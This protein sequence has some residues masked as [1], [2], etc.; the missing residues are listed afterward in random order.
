MSA[1]ASII[2]VTYGQRDLTAQCL[3]SLERCL[4]DRLGAEFELV[5]VDNASPDATPDLLRAWSDRAVVSLLPENRNFAGGCNAGAALATG[6]VLIFLNNDTVVTPGAL[7]ALADQALEPGVSAAGCRLH[8][9]DGTIQHAGVAFLHSS[10]L[11]GV[12]M[13]Q[14][15]FHHQSPELPAALGTYELDCVTAACMSV[16]TAVFRT[17]GGFDETYVNGLEDVDLC[18]RLR[19]AGGTIVYRGDI[20]IVHHEGASRGQGSE[21]WATPARLKAMRRNDQHF[22]D[23][24][25]PHLD[26]DDELAARLWGSAVREGAPGR[27]PAA[28][29]DVVVAGQP[30]G[31]GPGSS[32]A[33]AWLA[34]LGRQGVAAA[35]VDHPQPLVVPRLH[36][37][38][39]RS[40]D[41]AMRRVPRTGAAWL[42]I[43]AGAHDRLTVDAP[44][45]VRLGQLQTASPLGHAAAVWAAS[46]ALATQLIVAGLPGERVQVVPPPVAD[47]A[48]GSGGEGLLA[49]LPAHRPPAARAVLDALR[50]LRPG[51]AIRLVPTV[52]GRGVEREVR[53]RLPQAE[54]L[55][56][57]SEE[58][59]FARLAGTADVVAVGDDGD[60]FD[61]RALIAAS[62]G[63]IVV[64]VGP[65][66]PAAAFL[67]PECRGGDD[68]I[69][70]QGH[71]GTPAGPAAR[72]ARGVAAAR[73]CAPSAVRSFTAA[74]ATVAA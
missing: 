22:I 30:G 12:A 48:V 21:L 49:I 3:R 60:P 6:E 55:P 70:A 47:V 24:W 9:P 41:A 35:T 43:P 36:Q 32:E 54:L 17:V 1:R 45:I 27:D 31:I 71:L 29:A 8:F 20:V 59:T 39:A 5:L 69:S 58:I 61:R 33:R 16:R 23:R 18:L 26:Q 38:T 57:V 62:A 2:I 4:G 37:S 13:P 25:G 14:H 64:G 66:G 28:V 52:T 11:G 46:P 67:P 73:A 53:D 44:H 50:K 34:A 7:E 19:V 63:A 10:A 65:E 51:V 74:A 72:L 15:V 40:L 42:L 68:V 56:P